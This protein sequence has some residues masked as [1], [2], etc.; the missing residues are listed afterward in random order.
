MTKIPSND[1]HL[2]KQ[3]INKIESTPPSIYTET[4]LAKNTRIC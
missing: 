3:S 2:G 4:E 1:T